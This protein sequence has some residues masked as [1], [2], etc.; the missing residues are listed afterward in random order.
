MCSPL[1][2]R[3]HQST[4]VHLFKVLRLVIFR[5]LGQFFDRVDQIKPV[6]NVHPSVHAYVGTYVRTSTESF[7]GSV[8]FGI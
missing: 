7:F 8:K 2:S 6:S 5:F 3:Q 1:P 4:D